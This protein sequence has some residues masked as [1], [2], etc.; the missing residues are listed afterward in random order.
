MSNTTVSICSSG[1]VSLPLYYIVPRYVITLTGI[2]SNIFLLLGMI[3]DPLKCF[4]NSSSYLIMNLGVTDILTCSVAF[5][6][7]YW[8][9]CVNGYEMNTFFNFPSYIAYT[10][11]FTMASDRYMSCVHPFKYRVLITRRVSLTVIL[12]QVLLCIGYMILEVFLT[13]L[14]VIYSRCIIGFFVLLG[15][16]ILY[17]KATYV[18]K[19]NSRY[20]RD[21]TTL[22][23]TSQSR[24]SQS[25]RLANE[26]RLLTTMFLVSFITIATLAPFTAYELFSGTSHY[27]NENSEFS[28]RD[29][30][31]IL[32]RTL[33]LVNF[34]INPFMYAW[35]LMN[36]SKTFRTLV[37]PGYRSRENH[38]N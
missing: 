37:I 34:S 36:Y 23:S 30:Y 33:F 22:S 5:L 24:M 12:L 25:T 9:P 16:A 8:R 18:L 20:L 31:H 1:L 17:C 2:L 27:V 6:F 15:A 35:R 38:R 32:V 28:E 10:S 11:I 13:N 4:R 19:A 14:L 26:K 29:S 21:A 3:M 7:F